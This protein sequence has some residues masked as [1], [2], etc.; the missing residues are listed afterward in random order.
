MIHSVCG[1]WVWRLNK[2]VQ[3]EAEYLFLHEDTKSSL[4]NTECKKHEKTDSTNILNFLKYRWFF[5]HFSGISCQGSLPSLL[6]FSFQ[7]VSA[8]FLCIPR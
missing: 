2:K 3:P 6:F 7:Y 8:A 1:K 4:K 5:S